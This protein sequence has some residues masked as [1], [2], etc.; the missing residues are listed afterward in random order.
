MHVPFHGASLLAAGK[1]ELATIIEFTAALLS[2]LPQT[3][4]PNSLNQWGLHSRKRLAA[5]TG[6]Y[7][8]KQSSGQLMDEPLIQAFAAD[9]TTLR[10]SRASRR[11]NKLWA[12]LSTT[13]PFLTYHSNANV[14]KG[15]P[16]A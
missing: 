3:C 8:Q 7:R 5:S 16:T 14:L 15:T 6:T 4:A 10:C 13:F 12:P 9:Y 2:Q 1:K 11:K